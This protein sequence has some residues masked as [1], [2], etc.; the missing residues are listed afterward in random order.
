MRRKI[1]PLCAR[2]KT[3]RKNKEMY[4]RDSKSGAF[5]NQRNPLLTRPSPHTDISHKA[6][7]LHSHSQHT[8]PIHNKQFRFT[9]FTSQQPD[10]HA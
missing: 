3:K 9:T 2:K 8:G 4:K 5:D 6:F 10:P 1:K 7:Q